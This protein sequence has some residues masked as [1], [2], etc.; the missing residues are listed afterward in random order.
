MSTNFFVDIKSMAIQGIKYLYTLSNRGQN[1]IECHLSGKRV[2]SNE[3]KSSRK[4]QKECDTKKINE[5]SVEI[6]GHFG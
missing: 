5:S 1:N 6:I 2:R 4:A 3:V